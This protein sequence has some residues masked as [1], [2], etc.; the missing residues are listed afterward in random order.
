MILSTE[1]LNALLLEAFSRQTNWMEASTRHPVE[2]FIDTFYAI[3]TLM[4]KTI[5][6]LGDA[7]AR[8]RGGA[9]VRRARPAKHSGGAAAVTVGG[10][11]GPNFFGGRRHP[12]HL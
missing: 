1:T 5:A 12:Q 11:H 8:D 6:D 10:G 2:D 3:R 9:R 7:A 4:Q